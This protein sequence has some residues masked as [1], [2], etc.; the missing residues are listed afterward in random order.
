MAG[1]QARMSRTYR[2][3]IAANVIIVPVGTATGRL[4][5]DLIQLYGT[6]ALHLSPQQVG[7]ALGLLV[8]STPA[9]LAAVR[10]VP[11]F[12]YR[13]LMRVGYLTILVL[14]A[15]LGSVGLLSRFGNS[16]VLVAFVL[17]LLAIEVAISTSWGV[18][19]HPWMR[20][21]VDPADRPHFIARMRFT[22]GSASQVVTLVFAF[23]I[24][25]AVTADDFRGLLAV[26]GIGLIGSVILMGRLPDAGKDGAG[27]SQETEKNPAEV[28]SA[29]REGA[30]VALTDRRLRRLYLAFTLDSAVFLPMVTT[31]A[32]LYLGIRANIVAIVLA[33]S[34][35]VLMLATLTAGRLIRLFGASRVATW[36]MIGIGMAQLPWILVQQAPAGHAMLRT[37]VVYT[38]IMFS[39][40]LFAA[41]YGAGLLTAWYEAVPDRHS[42]ALFTLRDVLQSAKTQI[43]MPFA[44]VMLGFFTAIHVGV[45]G[46]LRPD[47]FALLQ[48]AGAPAALV[49]AWL[50]R[51]NKAARADGLEPSMPAPAAVERSSR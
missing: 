16:L 34:G 32:V 31:Y 33:V 40:R 36:S 38:T 25:A 17:V 8:L 20:I 24:G 50:L 13:R 44:G 51:P 41:G 18:A 19:W 26:L 1:N 15:A 42:T 4:S 3:A 47:V 35:M 45:L 43:M 2:T 49:I 30:R 5:A 10:L 46:W 9:Q 22:T 27:K 37:I 14:L 48:M 12:G 39:S 28:R 21:L 11:R 29:W 23:V 7:G 6:Q